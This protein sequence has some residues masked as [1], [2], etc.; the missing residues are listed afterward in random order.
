[1]AKGAAWPLC[2]LSFSSI[3]RRVIRN[4]ETF[5]R[6]HRSR[7]AGRPSGRLV[8]AI[9]LGLASGC[10]DVIGIEELRF[11]G[12]GR[13]DSSVSDG[14]SPVDVPPDA[15]PADTQDEPTGRD[16]Q[17]AVDAPPI[18]ARQSCRDLPK[19]CGSERVDCCTSL[20]VKGGDFRRDNEFL[21]PAK[22]SSFYLDK[23]DITV[24]RM[25]ALVMAGYGTQKKPPAKNS[26]ERQPIAGSG[27][28][29][30]WNKYLPA[31][32]AALR[33]GLACNSQYE[34]W[35]A[36]PSGNE[37]KPVN[38]IDWYLA[39][40]F[41][42][43]DGGWL[44]TEAEW[45]YAAAGGTEQRPYVWG[46]DAPRSDLANYGCLRSNDAGCSSADILPVG[47]LPKGDGLFGQSDLSGNLLQWVLDLYGSYPSTCDDCANVAIGSAR[48][49]RGGSF[50][51]GDEVLLTTFR[52]RGVPESAATNVGARC[53]RAAPY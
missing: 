53:A 47:M 27:W 7:P 20:E 9:L 26:G 11:A 1:M 30:D 15:R 40:A 37:N 16:V 34:T 12:S 44:P 33:A 23:F 31:D 36:E 13:P 21:Y 25:R 18:A 43:W 19:T 35:T 48:V 5:V 10:R 45:N 2:L 4:D 42:I 29:E 51:G 39:G 3:L 32:T 41:C 50:V 8:L 14:R 52:S 6:F 24:G 46:S 38:C 22:V 28:T 17:G 49:L